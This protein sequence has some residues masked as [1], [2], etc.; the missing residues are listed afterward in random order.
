MFDHRCYVPILRWKRGEWVALRCLTEE[1]RTSLT[2]LVEVTPK[3]FAPRRDGS[4]P[5]VSEALSKVAQDLAS[6]WGWRPVFLDLWHLRADLRSENGL[7][8]LVYL[9]AEARSRGASPIPV[10]GVGRGAEYQAAVA[11][12]AAGVASGVCIRLL[13]GD[14]DRPSL[15]SDIE[16]LLSRLEVER[17]QTDLIVDLQFVG[18]TLPDWSWV[19]R[20]IPH[21]QSWRTL[22]VASG[23]FPRDLI[24]FS[25]GEHR[26]RRADWLGWLR[27]AR[28]AGASERLP[29]FADYAIQHGVYREPPDRANVSASIRYT[30]HENWV[31]MRGRGLRTENGPGSAQYHA[32]ARWLCQSPEIFCGRNFSYGDG[33]IY[34]RSVRTDP[35]GSPETL[36]RA[37][38]NHHI[39]FV[40]RQIASLFAT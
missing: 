9:A 22:T 13:S 40:A 33:Y 20:S 5:T 31:I 8:A 18:D 15:E 19:L 11:S 21:Q 2:P 7:H 4:L 3:S 25:V 27:V 16:A 30:S 35:P 36:L 23:S 39:T 1:V 32:E 12:A 6:N 28:T 34:E 26:V 37:G 10:T 17:A 24:R 14:L 38:F 29:T